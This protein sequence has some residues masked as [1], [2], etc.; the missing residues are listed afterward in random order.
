M[1]A[2][3]KEGAAGGLGEVK[4]HVDPGGAVAVGVEEVD[5]VAFSGGGALGEVEGG[6]GVQAEGAGVD[7]G[8]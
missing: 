8:G 5:P 7:V 2:G 4:A 3:T 6:A 1:A